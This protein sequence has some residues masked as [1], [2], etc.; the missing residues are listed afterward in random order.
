MLQEKIYFPG[1]AELLLMQAVRFIAAKILMIPLTQNNSA[2]SSNA[3][4]S[5]GE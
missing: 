1:I 3:V 2:A 4:S 5:G